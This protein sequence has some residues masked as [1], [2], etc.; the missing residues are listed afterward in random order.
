MKDQASS[1]SWQ[2]L[3]S[4]F[5]PSSLHR[6][7]ISS[8]WSQTTLV[9]KR[10]C[11]SVVFK[12]IIYSDMQRSLRD[13][14]LGQIMPLS[15]FSSK[16]PFRI[17]KNLTKCLNISTYEYTIKSRL[18]TNNQNGLKTIFSYCRG[19]I[20]VVW[21]QKQCSRCI[22]KKFGNTTY[23][24][25]YRWWRHDPTTLKMGPNLFFR[26]AEIKYSLFEPK[27]S[28]LMHF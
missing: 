4:W 10:I 12:V 20:L 3:S 27:N 18:S 25:H 15:Q 14:P 16:L 26:I 1:K 8:H 5:P 11:L 7:A 23:M 17:L 13:T 21:A 19:Q 28:A 6:P 24:L 22:F 2:F 9:I